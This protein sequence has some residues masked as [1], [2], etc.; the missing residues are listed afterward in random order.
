MKI[1][2][3]AIAITGAASAGLENG[4]FN[5]GNIGWNVFNGAGIYDY[6][7]N[8]SVPFE[9]N[10]LATW[11]AFT[12][13]VGYSG[14][15][16][17]IAA[18]TWSE[19]D[20]IHY[21]ANA[22][23]ENQLFADNIGYVALNF[24]GADGNWWFNHTTDNVDNSDMDGETHQFANSI[25]LDAGAASAA[26]IEFVIIFYQPW[27]DESGSGSIIWDDA[28][29]NVVPAPGALALLGLAGLAGRR[30]RRN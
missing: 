19:G 18:G 6:A 1:S 12:G 17:D 15:G 29:A 24:F 7:G 14:A 23:V 30:R 10:A 25:T 8:P 11:G 27:H 2:I 22:F 16:Q 20:T 9:S 5:G 13:G 21:G 28:Y 3:L 26:R 4:D